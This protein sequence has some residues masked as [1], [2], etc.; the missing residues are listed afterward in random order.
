MISFALVLTAAILGAMTFFAFFVAPAAAIAGSSSM[1]VSLSRAVFPRAFDLFAV[2]AVLA[3]LSASI[4]G[5]PFAATC[6]L[7]ATC[8]FVIAG[9]KI[10][11]ALETARDAARAGNRQAMVDFARSRSSA[12][13]ANALQY[14]TLS[15]AVV[16]LSI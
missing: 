1:V 13:F 14:L 10:T 15:A 16:F 8:A 9:W 11:P 3:T 7:V 4:A 6:L 5:K 2:L 12:I